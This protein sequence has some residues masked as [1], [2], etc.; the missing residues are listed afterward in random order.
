MV[1]LTA[2]RVAIKLAAL[3]HESITQLP[4]QLLIIVLGPLP[5]AHCP[6]PLAPCLLP[7]AYYANHSG[8]KSLD[9]STMP[10]DP[11]IRTR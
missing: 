1:V 8:L 9:N 10:L 3:Y 2:L 5:I 11:S 4:S 7:L 6:L